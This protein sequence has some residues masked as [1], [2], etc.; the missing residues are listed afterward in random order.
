ME[1]TLFET[2]AGAMAAAKNARRRETDPIT[3]RTDPALVKG[4]NDAVEELVGIVNSNNGHVLLAG[5]LGEAWVAY[6][7]SRT[8]EERARLA[9]EYLRALA[10]NQARLSE[11]RLAER[12]KGGKP[13]G[14]PPAQG[15]AKLG[16]SWSA[17]RPGNG[18]DNPAK[19][20]APRG[21]KG[22]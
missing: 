21:I 5:Q 8:L 15:E 2:G 7:Q 10:E 17:D 14:N 20:K 4:F 12:L 9:V 13:E 16:R 1:T 22:K 19:V 18:H 6:W 3:I 11:K